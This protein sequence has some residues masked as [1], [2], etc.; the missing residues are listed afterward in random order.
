MKIRT[1]LTTAV[2]L[3]TVLVGMIG[4]GMQNSG[5]APITTSSKEAREA[6]LTGRDLQEKL[7][8]EESRPYLEEAI[9]LDPDFAMAHLAL[10]FAEP[11][12]KQFF[13]RMNKAA[14]LVDK[15]SE[16]ERLWILGMQAATSSNPSG[17]LEYYRQLVEM[18]PDDPRANNLMAGHYFNDQDW[19][20]AI[21]YYNRAL[22]LDSS[23]SVPYNQMGY[24]YRFMEDYKRAEE[25]F[26]K[27]IELIPD[28][29]NPYDSY[30][31]LLA[32]MGKYD[33]SIGMY[34]KALAVNPEFFASHIGIASDLCFKDEYD[35]ARERLETKMLATAP[36][37]G[38][39]RAAYRAVS[40]TYVYE[41]RYEEAIQEIQKQY[42]LAEEIWDASAMAADLMSMGAI[43]LEAN[44]PEKARAVFNKSLKL[45]ENSEL[46]K[47]VKDNAKRSQMVNSARV[48]I[49]N[50][51][52]ASAKAKAQEYSE[53]A[54]ALGDRGQISA[55]HTLAA[56][57]ALEEQKYGRAIEE[58][59]QADQG[60]AYTFYRMML[61]YQG[62]NDH[63]RAEEMCRQVVEFNQINNLSYAFI[64]NKAREILAT[65]YS[66]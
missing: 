5:L 58:L 30:A 50:K 57:I 28:D 49:L 44:A 47:S 19:E 26:K 11:S 62:L 27:Y 7:R 29:P 14:A 18:Y 63:E 15:V 4:C 61:A 41:G 45:M 53:I 64:R 32:K 36:N 1:T 6:Y 34:E 13:A 10:A 38:V 24:A 8:T 59:M 51:D 55:S 65:Q 31:E 25:A 20:R 39:R 66:P 40:V 43:Y 2:A 56:I 16:G 22:L 54:R 17:E 9:R 33:E 35:A 21:E 23:Y 52:L 60:S 3:G 37:D 46:P 12:A 42:A 48:S